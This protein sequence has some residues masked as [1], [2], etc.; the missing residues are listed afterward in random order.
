MKTT[1]SISTFLTAPCASPEPPA[2]ASTTPTS[3]APKTPVC[4]PFSVW[5]PPPAPKKIRRSV[6]ANEVAKFLDFGV[7]PLLYHLN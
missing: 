2:A 7:F 5:T 4:L 6:P 1:E 3:V